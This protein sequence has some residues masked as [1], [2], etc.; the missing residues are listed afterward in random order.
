MTFDLWGTIFRLEPSEARRYERRRL[1]IWEEEVSSWAARGDLA[2][3]PTPPRAAVKAAWKEAQA[4]AARGRSASIEKQSRH[5][6]ELAG[7]LHQPGA[8]ARRL[9]PLVRKL[10]VHVDREVLRLFPRL[11]AQGVRLGVVSNLLSE[12]AESVRWLL[13]EHRLLRHFDVLSLSEELPWCKPDPR[14][15]QMCLDEMG[16][17]SRETVHVGDAPED[18]A[19][20][21]AAGML[22][23]FALGRSE[24]RSASPPSTGPGAPSRGT[25]VVPVGD[26][27]QVTMQ[28]TP[29]PVRVRLTGA[30]ARRPA[31]SRTRKHGRAPGEVR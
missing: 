17:R 27:S 12:P 11:E 6:A 8:I 26:L 28:L 16:V 15:F 5:A 31:L 2:A 13:A 10:P 29:P 21:Q 4:C 14:I 22:A 1:E 25:R 18:V 3:R 7:R 24:G 23:V 20:A 19:G 30:G 9:D